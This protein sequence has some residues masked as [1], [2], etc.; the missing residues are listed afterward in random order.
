[1]FDKKTL[2]DIARR[3]NDSWDGIGSLSD[4]I[5]RQIDMAQSIRAH[6]DTLRAARAEL[7]ERHQNEIADADKSIA[8][9]QTYCHH[10]SR[11]YHG[12]AAGGS[13][14]YHVCSICGQQ[15]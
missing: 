13:D 11:T 3:A 4:W 12:D 1:M 14:S 5:A 2:R 6:V 7:L 15:S 9:A 10:E 8:Q